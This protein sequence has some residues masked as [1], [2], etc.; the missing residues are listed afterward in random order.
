VDA[1]FDRAVRP[2]CDR[3]RERDVLGDGL[4]D[5]SRAIVASASRASSMANRSPMQRR[6][7]PPKGKY[8]NFGN[9][10][11]I[12]SVQRDGRNCSG[13][14]YHWGSRWTTHCWTETVAPSGMR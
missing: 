7:P 1:Q 4:N 13:S 6:G 9:S 5:Q 11:R 10:D 3:R 8:A 14:S 12:S 2:Q